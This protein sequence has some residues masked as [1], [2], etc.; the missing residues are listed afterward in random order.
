MVS[1]SEYWLS[2]ATIAFMFIMPLG[3][4]AFFVLKGMKKKPNP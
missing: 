3:I 4:G 2:I 1:Q